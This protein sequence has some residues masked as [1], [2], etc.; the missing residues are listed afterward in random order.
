MHC[1]WKVHQCFSC[2]LDRHL[3]SCQLDDGMRAFASFFRDKYNKGHC[4]I[5][6]S[7]DG[8]L[9]LA[10]WL[11]FN[12]KSSHVITKGRISRASIAITL[13]IS[14]ILSNYGNKLSFEDPVVY[15]RSLV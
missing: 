13:C 6:H 3:V 4:L 12:E 15:Q 9:I 14:S 2:R 5:F 8:P 10:D 11:D 7:Q 1:K